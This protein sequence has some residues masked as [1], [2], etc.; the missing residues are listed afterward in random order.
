MY[1]SMRAAWR[2]CAVAVTLLGKAACHYPCGQGG[3][4]SPLW[5]RRRAI[6][7]VPKAACHHPCGQ[8]GVPSSLW[9]RRRAI[10]LAGKAAC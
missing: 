8:G 4:P 10:I 6:T 1:S 9:T 2:S 3:V 7:L 5:A